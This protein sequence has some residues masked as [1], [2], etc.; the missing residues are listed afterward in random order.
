[1][2]A[3]I[4]FPEGIEMGGGWGGQNRKNCLTSFIKDGFSQAGRMAK[5]EEVS[6]GI[7]FRG[8]KILGAK[9]GPKISPN[10]VNER[11]PRWR[12]PLH[13]LFRVESEFAIP[14]IGP[15]PG[16]ARERGDGVLGF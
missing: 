7:K 13:F 16:W 6:P 4:L 11:I 15:H 5:I 3:V 1:M 14:L 2:T 12:D 10:D 9:H 8:G